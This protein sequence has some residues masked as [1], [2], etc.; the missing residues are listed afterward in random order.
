MKT[1]RF[2]AV[3]AAMLLSAPAFSI[4][5]DSP[6]RPVKPDGTYLFAEHDTCS[7]YM[8]IYYPPDR[9]SGNTTVL[10]IFGG[11]FMT[12]SR[13]MPY[14][15]GFYK[16][17]LEKGYNLI[18]IDYRLG[19][20]GVRK[21]GVGQVRLLEKAIDLAVED[22]YAATCFVIDNAEEL[23]IDPSK[24]VLV[25]SSAGAITAL[26]ADYEICNG[27]EIAE[28]L[29]EGFRYAGIAAYSGAILSFEGRPE[30]RKADPAPTFFNHGTEDRLVTY[31][32]IRF[33][34][35]GFFGAVPLT[36]V[37]N[38]EDYPYF[39]I[40][41][42]GCGHEIATY[43]EDGIDDLDWFI[44]HMVEEK[45]PIKKDVV[46]SDPGI[47]KPEGMSNTIDEMYN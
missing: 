1:M 11:G 16:A 45:A 2:L 23:M 30:Y 44:R 43:M 34:N 8:D 3:I 17:V 6:S 29:P 35:I 19:L 14:H 15:N 25:G 36:K 20:K 47:K 41:Y 38:K 12:G 9:E 18:A 22:L 13:D 26:Q 46:L 40:R 24:I 4:A 31:K 5:E 28:R 10:F 27:A 37:F 32:K 42:S 7:L 39:A 21:M 33:F